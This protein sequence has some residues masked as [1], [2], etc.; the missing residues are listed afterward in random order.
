[1]FCYRVTVR[2]D[3]SVGSLGDLFLRQARR[4]RSAYS[5]RLA[6]LGLTHAQA[7]AL[8][9]IA[10]CE[11]PP[12]MVDLAERLHVVPRAATRL[13][14]ALEEADLVRRRIDQA[15][16]RSTLLELTEH[17]RATREVFGAARREAAESLF[18]PLSA[19]QRAALQT[20]L[21]QID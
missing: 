9:I 2:T 10:R 3:E 14:D 8:D 13:V 6:P 4:I 20:L 11:N 7:R 15:N 21:E 12:R 5:E 19:E 1:M 17:G 18:A 16:R